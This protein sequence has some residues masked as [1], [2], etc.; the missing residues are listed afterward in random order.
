MIKNLFIISLIAIFIPVQDSFAG[1]VLSVKR[2]GRLVGVNYDSESNEGYI[3]K[4]LRD[5]KKVAYGTNGDVVAEWTSKYGSLTFNTLG[6]EF[7]NGGVNEAG[8]T[9]EML[10]EDEAHYP[11]NGS[12]YLSEF[13]WVQYN[14]D[15]F[16]TAAEV[17]AYFDT[18][19]INPI[20]KKVHFIVSDVAARGYIID[21]ENGKM[22]AE[23]SDYEFQALT[24]TKVKEANAYYAKTKENI[25]Y[26]SRTSL[27]RFSQLSK[28]GEKR[29]T[30]GI[31][32]ML[33]AME[34]SSINFGAYKTQFTIIYD[35]KGKEIR[36][37]SHDNPRLKTIQLN[38][39]TY[40]KHSP[41]VAMKINTPN[42]NW[43][44][45]TPKMNKEL[46]SKWLDAENI[47]LDEKLLNSHMM[48]PEE[49]VID[50]EYQ[51]YHQHLNIEFVTNKDNTYFTYAIISGKENFENDQL[52]RKSTVKITENSNV[53][54]EY[55]IPVNDYALKIYKSEDS[56]KPTAYSNNAK[57]FFGSPSYEKAKFNLA[58]KNKLKIKVN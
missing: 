28:M 34:K 45:Y 22:V 31:N 15:N 36:F 14:L 29:E 24:N 38:R 20:A 2:V 40:D 11:E 53:A 4:N 21:F 37:K 46:L 30:N 56:K 18:V 54:K 42:I 3:I 7:P 39:L 51:K 32:G 5:I 10:I 43:E 9:I 57:S 41:I 52:F 19:T 47:K 35:L 23:K 13:E 1:S 48:N 17:H 16:K 12:P 55:A 33:A 26:E 25:N 50:L 58:Q 6:K 8:L 44:R 27:D 49:K